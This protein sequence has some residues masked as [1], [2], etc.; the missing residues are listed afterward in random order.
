M[1]TRVRKYGGHGLPQTDDVEYCGQ[2]A[3]IA[4]PMR[5]RSAAGSALVVLTTPIISQPSS[6]SACCNGGSC[7]HPCR[8]QSPT[9]TERNNGRRRMQHPTKS[10]HINDLHRHRRS[11]I[12]T[13]NRARIDNICQQSVPNMAERQRPDNM[14]AERFLLESYSLTRWYLSIP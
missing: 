2:V 5:M 6:R 13:A 3:L 8:T 9:C 12:M 4:L 7:Q 1:P 11:T 14:S 10:T